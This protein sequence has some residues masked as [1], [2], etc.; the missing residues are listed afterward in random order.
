MNFILFIYFYL[1]FSLARCGAIPRG[2]HIGDGAASSAETGRDP[3][4]QAPRRRGQERSQEIR[5]L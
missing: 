1:H 3:A 4:Y 2:T 5:L